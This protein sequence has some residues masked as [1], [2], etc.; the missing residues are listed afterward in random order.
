[1]LTVIIIVIVDLILVSKYYRQYRKDNNLLHWLLSL[2]G[3]VLFDFGLWGVYIE[4][5]LLSIGCAIAVLCI[6]IVKSKQ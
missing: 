3:I 4:K 2:G 5:K 1:M 6:G